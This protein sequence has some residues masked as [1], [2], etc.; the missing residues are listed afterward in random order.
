MWEDL[1]KFIIGE[2]PSEEIRERVR[3]ERAERQGQPQSQK[4]SWGMFF[5]AIAIGW[6]LFVVVKLVLG[7]IIADLAFIPFCVLG[8]LF[9]KSRSKGPKG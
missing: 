1:R 2:P 4:W 7:G 8:W 9:L 3:R 5:G 6:G